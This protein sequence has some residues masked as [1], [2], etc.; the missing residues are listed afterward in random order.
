MRTW[1]ELRNEFEKLAAEAELYGSRL[2]HVEKEG[3]HVWTL[4]IVSLLLSLGHLLFLETVPRNC[5]R[6]IDDAQIPKLRSRKPARVRVAETT[7]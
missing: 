6:H 2:D 5:G 1:P 4:L 3:L 7:T